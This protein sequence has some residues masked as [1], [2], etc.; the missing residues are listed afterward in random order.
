MCTLV[1]HYILAYR[2]FN[3]SDSVGLYC[4]CLQI[5]AYTKGKEQLEGIAVEQT[6]KIANVRM[7][8]ERVI[9]NVR[10]KYSILSITQQFT[11]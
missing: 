9:G 11:L 5:A 8:V 10:N 6:Q 2:G 3:I 4:S 7:H 1:I